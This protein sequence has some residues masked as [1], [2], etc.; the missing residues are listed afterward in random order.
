VTADITRE[1]ETLLRALVAKYKADFTGFTRLAQN[2]QLLFSEVP[3]VHSMRIRAKDPEHLFDKL[4]RKLDKCREAGLPF[5]I[6]EV[7]L[8]QKINDLAGVRLLH[9]HTSQFPA[10][11]AAVTRLLNNEGYT[12]KE[13]PVARTWDDEYKGIFARM[14]VKTEPNP[15]MYT[16][17]HYVV[18]ES[19]R[20]KRTAE[21]QIRTL[22]EELWGEVDHSL[23]YPLPCEVSS[24]QEQIKVL[25]RATSTCTRLVDSIF[26]T[27]QESD[28]KKA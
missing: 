3:Y 2:L 17:V 19:S 25:A 21:L 24:C 28:P 6:T 10:I 14:D 18:E 20:S 26:H 8:T 27:K 7:N 11:N 13:G 12:L 9:L 1:E 23:N 16:S 4:R 15:R 5:D 22:A